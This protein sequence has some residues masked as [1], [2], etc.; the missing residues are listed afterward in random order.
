MSYLISTIIVLF[1]PYLLSFAGDKITGIEND[2]FLQKWYMGVVYSITILSL[3]GLIFVLGH[4]INYL[5][6]TNC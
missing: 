5:F 3:C 1:V 6:I 4:F 2:T